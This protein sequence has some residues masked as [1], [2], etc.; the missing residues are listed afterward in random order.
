MDGGAIY[1]SICAVFFSQVLGIDLSIADYCTLFF[2]CTVASIG[3]AG[4]PGG[5]LLFL[6]MVLQSVGIPVDCVLLVAT[7][8]RLLDMVTTVINITGDACVTL[9]IDSSEGTL[10]KDKYNS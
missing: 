1:Q 8:D 9:L 4:I 6:G 5:V 2:M 7:V 10:D 3:G